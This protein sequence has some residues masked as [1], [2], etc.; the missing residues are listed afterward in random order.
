MAH[1]LKYDS[2]LGT[3]PQKI[4]AT[5]NGIKVGDDE[6]R[7]LSERNPADLP[8][9]ELDV[10]VVVE[11]TGLFTRARQGRRPPRRRRAARGRLG[12]IR[13]RRRHVRDGCQPSGLRPEVAGGRVLRQLHHQ[14]LRA[15]GQGARRRVRHRAGPDD[16]HPRLHRRP[17]ARRR[18]AQGPATGPRRGDQHHPDEHGCRPVN[19]ARPRGH[20]GQARRH[21]DAGARVDR[22]G[23]RLQRHPR[24]ARPPSP[25]STPP[26]PRPPSLDR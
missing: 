11:S 7:V 2:I 13:R 24:P 8:W 4:S 6:L 19:V 20:E 16:H 9:K 5:K 14:L 18:A 12:A 22:L 23:H 15:D 25:R 17:D 21:V 3:L 26:S 10:D 1:L